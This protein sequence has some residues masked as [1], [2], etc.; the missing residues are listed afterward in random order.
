MITDAILNFAFSIF[1]FIF[2]KLPIPSMP[3]WFLTVLNQ[4]GGYV[5]QGF[6]MFSWLFPEDY[7][8]YVL[9]L[10]IACLTVRFYY[11]LYRKFHKLRSGT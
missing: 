1:D 7:Y 10:G 4:L 3:S 11:D 5:R 8:K 9:D 2:E 6:E